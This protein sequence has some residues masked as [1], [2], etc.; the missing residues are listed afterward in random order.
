MLNEIRVGA[1]TGSNGTVN[2][3]RGTKNGATATAN[4]QDKYYEQ[5]VG[6]NV[7]SLVLAAWT[8]T[9]NAGNI[10]SAA[11]AAVTQFALW[12]PANSGKN[13]SLLKFGVWPISGTAPVAGVFHSKGTAPTVASAAVTPVANNLAGAAVTSVAG[14]MASAA[15]AALTGGGALTLIRAADLFITAGTVA[16]LQGGRS[17][18]N[19]DGDIVIPPGMMWVPTWVA[20]GTTFLGGYSI[21]WEEVAV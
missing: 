5:V 21:T 20:A 12:N 15:G 3:A 2:P 18:E 9:V 6:G 17:I 14:Y 1:I 16:N 13:L 7:F 8:T 19:I 10:N 4:V 11:A